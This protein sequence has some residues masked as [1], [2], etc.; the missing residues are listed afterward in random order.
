MK[1]SRDQN[2]KTGLLSHSHSYSYSY[3]YSHSYSY[4]YSYSYSLSFLPSAICYVALLGALKTSVA[5]LLSAICYL[6]FAAF[7]I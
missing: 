6:L 1:V 4:S 7:H 3:S 5:M 2:D